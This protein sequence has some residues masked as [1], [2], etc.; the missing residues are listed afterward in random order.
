MVKTSAYAY[1]RVSSDRQEHARQ[2][3]AIEAHARR[4]RIEVTQWFSEKASGTLGTVGRAALRELL[5]EL[6]LNGVTLVLV[7]ASDRVGRDVAVLEQVLTYAG[8]DAD[9]LAV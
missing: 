9:Q 6:A 3:A 7:E 2:V 1:V 4:E 5:A 8:S